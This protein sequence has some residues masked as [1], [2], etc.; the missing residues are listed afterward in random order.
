[1]TANTPKIAHATAKFALNKTI[2]AMKKPN[3]ATPKTS[4]QPAATFA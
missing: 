1:M 4:D 2:A 3:A